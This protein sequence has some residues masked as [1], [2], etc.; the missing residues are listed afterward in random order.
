MQG[1]DYS[2]LISLVKDSKDINEFDFRIYTKQGAICWFQTA[3]DVIEYKTSNK[4]TGKDVWIHLEGKYIGTQ[5]GYP[6]YLA[7]LIDLSYQK[8][9]EQELEYAK[10]YKSYANGLIEIANKDPLTG[11]DNRSTFRSKVEA[12][13][14]KK[15][16]SW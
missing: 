14:N 8:Q 11:L 2:N 3:F 5:N 1:M 12:Y 16:L 15:R 13:R 7:V 10:N 9:L 6:V 4:I